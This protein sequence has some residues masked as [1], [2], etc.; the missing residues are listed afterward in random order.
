VAVVELL[1]VLV[2]LESVAFWV[3]ADIG[4]MFICVFVSLLPSPHLLRREG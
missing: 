4:K 3:V 2:V 1:D